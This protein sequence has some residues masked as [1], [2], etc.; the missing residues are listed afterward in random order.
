MGE[1]IELVWA[2]DKKGRTH[3]EESVEDGHTWENED[4]TTENKME[5]RAPM[6]HEKCRTESGRGDRQGD[7]EK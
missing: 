1:A 2:C 7:M 5:I 4:R 6:R 3:T